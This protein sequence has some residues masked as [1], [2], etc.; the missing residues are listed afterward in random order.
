MFLNQCSR[1]SY[2]FLS[3]LNGVNCSARKLYVCLG[4]I[5]IVLLALL[6][7]VIQAAVPAGFRQSIVVQNLVNPTRMAI[8]PDG[9]IFITEQAGR[10]RIVEQGTLL[11]QPFLNITT[12]VNSVGERGLLG[13]AF[14]P[15]FLINQWV[16]V[17][18]TSKTPVVH[19]RVSRFK[20]NGDTVLPNSEDILLD[21][22]PSG[23]PTFHNGGAIGFGA[24]GKLYIAVGDGGTSNNAQSL[25]TLKGKILRINK[26]GSIPA[27]NP[28]YQT[29][30]GINR[31]I[32]ARGFRNPYSFAVQNETGLIYINDVGQ[33]AWEEVNQGVKGANYGWP[34]V[35][36][37]S[38]NPQYRN[39]IMAYAHSPNALCTAIV[40]SAFYNPIN[41]RFPPAYVGDYF[42]GDFCGG[43]IR[44][45][46]IATKTNVNFA[47][48]MGQIV[49]IQVG[50]G[51]VMYVL[52]KNGGILY[53][54]TY[55]N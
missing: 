2:S 28:F 34:F 53:S 19:N 14:D 54:I 25:G 22:Q 48:N 49:D 29:A 5:A 33:D 27:D 6:P 36:G 13:I 3:R 35:E 32:W 21:I 12:R 7:A 42:Y 39:P 8:A 55:G 47:T 30:T 1:Q 51:G 52:R 24:D 31:A 16:Y 15:D 18:Y 46:D 11:P 10:I 17:F 38:S 4:S 41:D 50:L 9:R 20:A 43:W 37:K 40:G 45:Y 23:A 26:D 44:R